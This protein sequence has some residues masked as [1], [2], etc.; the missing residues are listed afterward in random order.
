MVDDDGTLT[1]ELLG[2]DGMELCR[3]EV[4]PHSMNVYCAT[5]TRT[6]LGLAVMA[7]RPSC[8]VGAN[9]GVGSGVQTQDAK[10]N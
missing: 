3:T 6:R 5:L 9:Q 2:P 4:T 7:T 8:C 1:G 10:P